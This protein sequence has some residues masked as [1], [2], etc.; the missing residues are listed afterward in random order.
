MR[1]PLLHSALALLASR[2]WSLLPKQDVIIASGCSGALEIAIK[3]LLSEGD[4]IILPKPGFS[5]YQTLAQAYGVE[6]RFYDLLPDRSWEADLADMEKQIDGR[7]R[8]IL[9]NNPSNPCGSVYS[10]EHLQAILAVAE[11]HRVPIIADEIYGNITFKGHEFHPIA[12][13]TTEV[14]VLSVGGL[15]KEFLVPGWRVGWLLIHDRNESL[16]DV[17]KGLLKLTQLIIGANTLV[18]SAIPAILTPEG[19]LQRDEVERSRATMVQQLESNAEITA[20]ILGKVDGL[21]CIAA[22]GAMYTMCGIDTDKIDIKDDRAFTQQLLD[23][24]F[25]V[26][27]PGQCFG[28]PKFFRIFLGIPAVGVWLWTAA[29]RGQLVEQVRGGTWCIMQERSSVVSV[30]QCVHYSV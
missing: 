20:S 26:V 21:M 2:L 8:A 14:P 30:V 17:R 15:A 25:V 18:Q 22:Q 10:K 28:M 11:K 29:S 12:T 27:L 24:E 19:A 6:C 7:T 5:L 1:T 13:L 23:E 3:G 4:N 9:V 16:A